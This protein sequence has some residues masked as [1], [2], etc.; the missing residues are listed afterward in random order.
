MG[1]FP[2][3][4]VDQHCLARGRLGRLLVALEA[5]GVE[6]GY[7]VAEDSAIHV[8]LSSGLVT[9]IGPRALAL[10]DISELERVGDEWRGVRL[11][12]LGGGATVD[13][14]T[15]QPAPHPAQQTVF[16]S[17]EAPSGLEVLGEAWDRDMVPA[18]VEALSLGPATGVRAPAGDL[19]LVLTADAKTRFYIDPS[20]NIATVTAHH[21]RLDLI[22]RAP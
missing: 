19:S 16:P 10:V 12:L 18:L 21:I 2:Y 17:P 8:D 15:G 9:T 3:G 6:R 11:S 22:H 4:L 20:R 14:L 7:G 13:A 5:A 1:L